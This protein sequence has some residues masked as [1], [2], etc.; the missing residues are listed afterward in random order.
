MFYGDDYKCEIL[1]ECKR[2]L[3]RGGLLSFSGHDYGH[4]LEQHSNCM[5]G[6]RFYP[7]IS[8]DIYWEIFELMDI[9]KIAELVRLK[10]FRFGKDSH[11][12]GVFF[13]ALYNK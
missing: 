8:T 12:V 11:I 1:S 5:E 4:L 2:I 7:Y 3:K 10:F 13:F 9:S 6:K